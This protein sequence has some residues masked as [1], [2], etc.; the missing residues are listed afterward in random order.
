MRADGMFAMGIR[1]SACTSVSIAF[2]G[3]GQLSVWKSLLSADNSYRIERAK[4]ND[5][6]LILSVWS[7]NCIS[8]AVIH[9]HWKNICSISIHLERKERVD[10][11]QCCFYW[12]NLISLILAVHYFPS[13][14]LEN[15]FNF[16]LKKVLL[17]IFFINF[18]SF[19]VWSKL[20]M[21][22]T[23]ELLVA[24]N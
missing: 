19:I 15:C 21:K 9:K 5:L 22:T 3:G 6:T 7:S 2:F 17:Y 8:G 14:A 13:L 4:W 1:I 23:S 20:T 10:S 24:F 12:R 11:L 18:V 16:I